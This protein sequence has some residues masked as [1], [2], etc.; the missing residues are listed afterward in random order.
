MKISIIT[1]SFNA[2]STI[3]DTIQ[4]IAGQTYRDIE[5]IVVDGG[6][7]DG[8][9][10][11][12]KKLNDGIS[13]WISEPDQGIYD[14]MNKGIKIASG[15]IIGFLNADDVYFD[16]DVLDCVASA[17]GDPSI[18]ACYSDLVYTEKNSLDQVVRYWKSCDFKKGLFKTGWVPP[19][20]TF[21]ARKSVYDRYGVYD[22]RYPLAADF[23]LM[24][25]F[26]ELYQIKTAYIPKVFTKMRLGGVTN[27]S[28]ANIVKQNVEIYKACSQNHIP[29][30]LASFLLGKVV[31]RV[32]QFHCRPAA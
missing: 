32:K 31:S 5:H 22:L 30:S 20:P 2:E 10:K 11:I 3:A 8:T 25:R 23:E 17:M 1:V 7:V 26:L 15:A 9:V 13:H 4:S 6:S 27:Q 19:H 16:T 12:I 21:F 28:L 24:A 18:D 29:L 14:A